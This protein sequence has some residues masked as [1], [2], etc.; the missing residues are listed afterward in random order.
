VSVPSPTIYVGATSQATVSISDQNGKPLSGQSVTWSTSDG[1]VAMVSST[2][3]ITAVGVG[4]ATITATSESKT[5]TLALTV[6]LVPVASVLVAPATKSL[7]VGQTQQL[8]A[9]T[10]DSAG[11]TLANR[12]IAWGTS[13]STKARV[14]AS[15]LATA[16]GVGNATI[17]AT[18]GGKTGTVTLQVSLV[19]VARIVVSPTAMT[20]QPWQTGNLSVIAY[21]SAGNP[22]SGRSF[23]W[24]SSDTVRAPVS[25]QGVVTGNLIGTFTI[26]AS[27]EGHSG[28]ATV[29]IA[30]ATS[31]MVG[32]NINMDPTLSVSQESSIAINPTN[33]LNIVA[34][35]NWAHFYSFDGGRSWTRTNVASHNQAVGD[36]NVTFD[37][38]GT[39]FRQGRGSVSDAGPN[40][41]AVHPSYDG[42]RT[43]SPAVLAYLPL[44]QAG[45]PDQGILAVD[46]V[47]KSPYVGTMYAIA[48]DYQVANAV[49]GYVSIG[50]PLIVVTSRDGGKTW[51]TPLDI[52]DSPIN[53]QEH[54]SYITTGPNGEV[55]AAWI[56]TAPQGQI[57]FAK[58]LNGGLS[59]SK[60][61]VVRA[62]PSQPPFLLVDDMRGNITIDVDRS[63][64]PHRGTIYVS[65]IDKNGPSGGAVDAWMVK[66][67]D[68][69][70]S[71][72][73][74]VL[75]SDGPHGP[76]SFEFQPRICVAPN[77]R[78]DAAW[79]E[80][81]SWTGSGTPSYDVYYSYSTNG[82]QSF[83]PSVRVTTA[84]SN[85]VP[86]V[87]GEYMGLTSDSTRALVSW[88]DMRLGSPNA[89]EE[90]FAVIWNTA[91]SVNQSVRLSKP[92]AI[93]K[94]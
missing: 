20:V 36:P 13:D 70:S 67:T 45:G 28:S 50:F 25:S 7:F 57:V 39:A 10:L 66:S 51:S 87:F 64:G 85:K 24:L 40:I 78:I 11:G 30:P 46:T 79:Y 92:P 76:L 77:G 6:A 73:N 82:G 29:K 19:P 47:S 62:D 23:T 18:S 33:P 72:S 94:P 93:K 4:N 16:L 59:W 53:A 17:T 14:S 71:W 41:L 8:T 5:G 26:S 74:P 27:S 34:S 60:N 37:N 3:L 65:S 35:T 68:G 42:G 38:R 52:S 89:P 90:F 49:T 81:R 1:T 88:S 61:V 31:V 75:L 32:P 80:I 54:S 55:Y 86:A 2:G 69:G 56:A 63:S 83:S 84:P 48:S 21:D 43:L 12:T 44:Q 15:G 9:T 91:M 22:L 58:S